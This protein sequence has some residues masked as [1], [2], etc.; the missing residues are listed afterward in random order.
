[1]A[2]ESILEWHVPTGGFYWTLGVSWLLAD[3]PQ[4]ALEAFENETLQGNREIGAIMA[5]HDLGRMDDYESRFAR[6]RNNDGGEE[7]LARIYAWIGDNDNAFE[8]LQRMIDTHG[9]GMLA[10]VDTDLYTK[11]K[12]D[13]R[14]QKMRSE[15]GFEA[16]EFESI[17][18][19]LSLPAGAAVDN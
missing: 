4:K 7:S 19:V 16:R 5:L 18:F 8:W 11:I 13:P 15:H 17:D 14:W 1:M 6:F 3:Q 9:P 2:M 12:T 10:K